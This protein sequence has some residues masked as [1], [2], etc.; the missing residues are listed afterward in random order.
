MQR[1]PD[2]SL[3]TLLNAVGLAGA[4]QTASHT[5]DA[6]D[7][8]AMLCTVA[9]TS[10]AAKSFADA[11]VVVNFDQIVAAAHGY[12]TGQAVNLTTTGALPGGLA[13]NLTYYVIYLDGNTVSLA[14]TNANATAGIQI[15]I[16]S[17][18]GGG[19]HQIV[20]LTLTAAEVHLEGSVDGTTYVDIAGSTNAVSAAG[21]FNWNYDGVYYKSVRAE[22]AMTGGQL[23]ATV[24]ARSVLK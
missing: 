15:D 21:S 2:I 14:T 13:N 7:G 10:T 11:N 16:T 17:A 24:K 9:L 5:R 6:M 23:L 20:P 19:T 8:F 12:L 18:A 4:K 22:F 1:D 3:E